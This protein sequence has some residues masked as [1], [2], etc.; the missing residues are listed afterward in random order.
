MASSRER[1]IKTRYS[2]NC[3]VDRNLEIEVMKEINAKNGRRAGT[4]AR[5]CH[6]SWYM[7]AQGSC[8]MYVSRYRYITC[9]GCLRRMGCDRG[10]V[11]SSHWPVSTLRFAP[12]PVFLGR[13]GIQ[14]G[15]EC[16]SRG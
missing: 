5:V 6:V 4:Q 3:L 11:A 9:G 15:Q 10:N 8:A 1:R 2:A 7:L 16:Y 13:E 12:H 14:I